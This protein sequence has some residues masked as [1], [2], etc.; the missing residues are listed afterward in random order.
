MG[1]KQKH[2]LQ[3][4]QADYNNSTSTSFNGLLSFFFF[5]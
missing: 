2:Y 1:I 3:I 4:V 5:P